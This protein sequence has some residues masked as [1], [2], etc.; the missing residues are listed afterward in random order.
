MLGSG[1]VPFPTVDASLSD[2]STNAIQN[3]AVN[4]ALS[5]KQATLVSG[6][7]IK[8]VGGTSLLGSGNIAFPTVDSALSST[9]TNAVQNKVINTALGGKQA[10]LVSGTNIKTV[11][12]TSLLGSGNVAVQPTL[13]SGTNIKTV[14]STS[15]LGSG[16]VAVQPTLVSGTNIKTVNGNSLLGSGNIAISGGGETWTKLTFTKN[17]NNYTLSSGAFTDY[18]L[19]MLLYTAKSRD[20]FDISAQTG[21][22]IF[23]PSMVGTANVNQ[24]T[25]KLESLHFYNDVVAPSNNRDR[26]QADYFRFTNSTKNVLTCDFNRYREFSATTFVGTSTPVHTIAEIYGLK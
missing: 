4:S 1:N 13:V 16:N 8:T 6:T 11:N 24:T 10:T 9:S 7:N 22:V 18:K 2:S 20:S 26:I 19:V 23:N 5:G 14:N 15:L 25:V 17:G 21:S 12:N 3:K